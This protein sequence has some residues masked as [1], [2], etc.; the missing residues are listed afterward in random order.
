[1]SLALFSSN[2][3]AKDYSVEKLDV[4]L[5]KMLADTDKSTDAMLAQQ[6]K[7]MPAEKYEQLKASMVKAKAL[8]R[9][10]IPMLTSEI[11]KC[12]ANNAEESAKQACVEKGFA[13]L[14]NN[15]NLMAAHMMVKINKEKDNQKEV[16]VWEAV[17]QK[18]SNKLD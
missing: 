7:K 6:Q 14:A 8:M 13:T 4:F 9:K 10:E 15:D 5:N 11:K 1:M 2:I 16:K 18:I 3:I 12:S 17:T